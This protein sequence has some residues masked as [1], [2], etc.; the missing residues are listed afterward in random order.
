MGSPRALTRWLNLRAHPWRA[1]TVTALGAGACAGAGHGLLEHPG[2]LAQLPGALAAFALLAGIEGLA[3]IICFA[4]L[5]PFLGLRG[6]AR[7]P[8]LSATRR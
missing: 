6:P 4:V 3:V 7:H 8:V 5:G 1:G 2:S